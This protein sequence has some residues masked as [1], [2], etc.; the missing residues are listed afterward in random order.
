MAAH[1]I[2]HKFLKFY[3]PEL[4]DKPDD[5]KSVHS[6]CPS[7]IEKTQIRFLSGTET[8][9]DK[10]PTA[11]QVATTDLA[12]LRTVGLSGRKAEYGARTRWTSHVYYH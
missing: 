10:F 2:L 3:F 9:Q 6:F 4:S 7:N 12:A 1:A 5:Q 11:Y 8:P